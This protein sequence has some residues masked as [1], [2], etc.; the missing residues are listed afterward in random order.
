MCNPDFIDS[1]LQLFLR[2]IGRAFLSK[3]I[4]NFH[5][6]ENNGSNQPIGNSKPEFLAMVVFKIIC[7]L[8][9]FRIS[10]ALF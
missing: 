7:C 4:S 5:P 3:S 1:E 10:C 9:W 8:G 6:R 2:R